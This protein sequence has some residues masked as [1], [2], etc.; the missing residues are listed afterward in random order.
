MKKFAFALATTAAL[1]LAA[2]G[3]ATDASEDAI[4]DTVEVPADEAMANTPDPVMDE[5][6]TAPAPTPQQVEEGMDSVDQ[7]A[8]QAAD[9][10]QAAADD[11]QA[12]LDAAEAAEAAQN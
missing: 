8:E 11:V 9:D 4:A 6:A 7:T 1:A 10:A 5:A 2:C 12:A 3:D